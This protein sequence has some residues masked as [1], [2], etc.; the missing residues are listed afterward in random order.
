M[1]ASLKNRIK[2][3]PGGKKRAVP[4][5]VHRKHND[6]SLGKNRNGCGERGIRKLGT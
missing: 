6:T 3:R 5:G 1:G 4:F 2:K